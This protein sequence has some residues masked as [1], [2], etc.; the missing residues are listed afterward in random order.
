MN[1]SRLL[2]GVVVAVLLLAFIP[3]DGL[4]AHHSI[5]GDHDTSKTVDLTGVL[6][7]TELENPH[8]LIR[9]DMNGK[10]WLAILPSPNRLNGLGIR[11]KLLV[12]STISVVGYPHRQQ[13]EIYAQSV[14]IDGKT[15]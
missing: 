6:K 11:T 3:N 5:A 1:I 13:N 9:I 15:T 4:Y 2:A 12:G 10:E 14:T 8:S 7:R